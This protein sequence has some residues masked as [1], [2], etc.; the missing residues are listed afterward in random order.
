M[1][2]SNPPGSMKVDF[3]NNLKETKKDKYG[4]EALKDDKK[5]GE[6]AEAPAA[7]EAEE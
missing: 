2:G 5:E 6:D 3:R 7:A 1:A 4:L